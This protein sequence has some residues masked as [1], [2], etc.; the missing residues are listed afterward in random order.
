VTLDLGQVRSLVQVAY[1]SRRMTDGSSIVNK[2]QLLVVDDS[3]NPFVL[4]PYE[5]PD[6]SQ[7]YTFDV[8]PPVN[9]ERIRFEALETTGGNTGAKEIQLFEAG[10]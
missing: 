8:N 5:T 2:F 3:A 7:L 4:G 10:P 9:V 1:R 6:P